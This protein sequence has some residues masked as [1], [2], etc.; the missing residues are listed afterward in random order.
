MIG[1]PAPGYVVYKDPNDPL[2]A[3]KLYDYLIAKGKPARFG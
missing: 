3:Q 2:A 1:S